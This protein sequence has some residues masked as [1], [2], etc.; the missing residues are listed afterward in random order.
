M[1]KERGLDAFLKQ[2]KEKYTCP[3]CGGIISIH[4]AEEENLTLL[5]DAVDINMTVDETESSVGSFNVDILATET[6]TGRKIVIENQL[7]DTNHDHFG[8]TITYTA[9]K[10]ADMI[11]WIV[12]KAREEHRLAVEWLNNHTDDDIGF[13]LL[14][15]ELWSI[16]QSEPAVKFNVVEKPNDWAKEIK[17]ADNV[18]NATKKL[19]LDYWTAFNEY[20]FGDTGYARVFKKRK[21]STDH[22][23]TVSLGS[24]EYHLS[25][26]MNTQKNILAVEFGIADNKEL[27]RQ[28]FEKKETIESTAGVVLD[29]RELP[30]RKMS[31]ILYETS[32][33]CGDQDK[34]TEQFE[35]IKE[36]SVKIAKAFKVYL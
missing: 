20:A 21:P 25:F 11:I 26:L 9:G 8:K 33:D 18:M 27:F 3:E 28:L 5:C 1:V 15:I 12:K 7:E 13:F 35:W 22:W 36:Y 16:N 31:R 23:Y 4:D 19:K 6:D 32:V 14:E 10:N 17:K 34:W 29:W 24:S 30:D 2:Q